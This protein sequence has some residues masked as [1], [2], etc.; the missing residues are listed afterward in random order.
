MVEISVFICLFGNYLLEPPTN[1]GTWDLEE[2]G[3]GFHPSC[4]LVRLP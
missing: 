3:L 4:V 1:T 2:D